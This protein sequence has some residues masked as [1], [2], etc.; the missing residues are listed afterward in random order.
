MSLYI[1][2]HFRV[3]ERAA[4]VDFIGRNDFGTLVSSGPSGLDA[5]HV[6]FLVESEGGKLTLLTHFARA[7]PHAKSLEAAEHVLAI[8]QG[9]HGY[10]SPSWYENHPAVPTWNYAVVHAS[11]RAK[12]IDEARLR[13]LLARLSAKY[14]SGRARP[15]R[16]QD[17]P[18]DYVAKMLNAITGF[19]IEVEKLEGKFKLSQNRPGRDAAL[20]ADALEAQGEAGLAGLMRN[21]PPT[22]RR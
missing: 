20:V 22:A 1:P 16:M 5:S 13:S 19:A 14:E 21:A 4:L 8:F 12:P 17:L 18:E 11:G 9:P 6:P 7:N 10:V 15:W 3:E 2:A